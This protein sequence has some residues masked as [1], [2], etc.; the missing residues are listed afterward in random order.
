[1]GVAIRD[2]WVCSCKHK[3]VRIS[4]A[5]KWLPYSQ[6]CWPCFAIYYTLHAQLQ[7]SLPFSPSS[8][9]SSYP[10]PPPILQ[11]SHI[12]NS[13]G[14]L[15]T[16]ACNGQCQPDTE[17][18]ARWVCSPFFL[19]S[20][21]TRVHFPFSDPCRASV[22]SR[23]LRILCTS[24]EARHWRASLLRHIIHSAA[25]KALEACACFSVGIVSDRELL[26]CL[27]SIWRPRKALECPDTLFSLGNE[28]LRARKFCFHSDKCS[29]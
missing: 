16:G 27:L 17:N 10:A 26:C 28:H 12:R 2:W 1:M 25:A 22:Y 8:S 29:R 14:L 3:V 9:S 11:F 7:V 20:F 18:S 13:S 19:I 23:L 4:I 15:H 5:V 24:I 21:D 6:S